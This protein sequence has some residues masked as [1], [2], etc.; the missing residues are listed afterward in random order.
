MTFVLVVLH[1]VSYQFSPSPQALLAVCLAMAADD[2][3]QDDAVFADGAATCGAESQREVE[4]RSRTFVLL[5]EREQRFADLQFFGNFVQA[6]N[7]SAA[8]QE[9]RAHAM[10]KAADEQLAATSSQAEQLKTVRA[11]L[12]AMQA[13]AGAAKAAENKSHDALA[14]LTRQVRVGLAKL[15]D[16]LKSEERTLMEEA[17]RVAHMRS[18]VEA[19][20]HVAQQEASCAQNRCAGSAS[21]VRAHLEALDDA[22]YRRDAASNAHHMTLERLEADFHRER[23]VLEARDRSHAERLKEFEEALSWEKPGHG[24][25]EPREAAAAPRTPD[26]ALRRLRFS[27][28]PPPASSVVATLLR[29]PA[30]ESSGFGEFQSDAGGRAPAVRFDNIARPLATTSAAQDEV[31]AASRLVGLMPPPVLH[32]EHQ[33]EWRLLSNVSVPANQ[34]AYDPSTQHLRVSRPSWPSVTAAA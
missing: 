27:A 28:L 21:A 3:V 5:E 34:A 16:T 1:G 32:K 13:E 10:A 33:A 14:L 15:R 25:F 8:E 9:I 26:N 4:L 24:G 23:C 2:A 18:V 20:R 6:A 30:V 22:Q 12:A 29:A 19:A 11:R 31:L 7:A 17:S